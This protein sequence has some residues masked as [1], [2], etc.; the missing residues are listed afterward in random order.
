MKNNIVLLAL[1]I[2]PLLGLSQ[3]RKH[4]GLNRLEVVSTAT[5]SVMG[6]CL[7]YVVTFENNSG[8]TI[9]GI[10]WTATFTDNFG[11]VLG[12]RE[13][14]W[15]SGNFITPLEPGE[16]AEDLETNYV[17]GGLKIWITIT[18]IHYVE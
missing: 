15:E 18:K 9:D 13:G 8:R 6:R 5:Q 4:K 17:K 2:L 10:K 16:T 7:G 14:R 3:K 12:V 11:E 1:I